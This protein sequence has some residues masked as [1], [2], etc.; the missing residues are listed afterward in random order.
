MCTKFTYSHHAI[1]QISTGKFT[2]TGSL[3]KVD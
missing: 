1:R 3:Y 2:Q